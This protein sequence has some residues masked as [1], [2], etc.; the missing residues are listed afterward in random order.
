M[1]VADVE[2][3]LLTVLQEEYGEAELACGV[4]DPF[5]GGLVRSVLWEGNAFPCTYMTMSDDSP[6]LVWVDLLV[7]MTSDGTY[8]TYVNPKL[9]AKRAEAEA[10]AEAD[11]EWGGLMDP[12]APDPEWLYRD[13]LTCADLVVP[14]TDDTVPGPD[15]RGMNDAPRAA[16]GG[17]SYPEVVYYFLDNGRPAAMDPD[18]DGRPCTSEFPAAQIQAFYDSARPV[19]GT[20]AAGQVTSPTV[21]TFDIRTAIARAGLPDNAIQVDC[22]L[23][24]PVSVG[25]TFTC[26]PRLNQMADLRPVIVTDTDGSYLLTPPASQA[27]DSATASA[28]AYRPGLSCEQLAAP[29]NE[30]TFADAG[31]SFE[32]YLQA[33]PGAG[34]TGLDYLGAVLYFHLNGSPTELDPNGHGWPCEQ[35][36][37]AEEISEV[38][39]QVRQ[40]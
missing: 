28:M 18:G 40:P 5:A 34:Q 6:D 33:F 24:G 8:A 14:V 25:S 30:S 32:E 12:A 36:F 15:F 39:S 21:T 2:A 16:Q 29:V 7:V 38:Q 19:Q 4:A 23:V 35:N 37:P 20:A 17:L 26:A 31:P 3:D 13:D 22:A 27:R 9:V 1:T 11:P 10:S